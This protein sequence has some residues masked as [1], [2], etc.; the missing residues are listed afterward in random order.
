MLGEFVLPSGGSAWTQ[1][2][3]QLL[4]ELE[5]KEKAG[6][7]AI[8]RMHE[9]GWLDR[10]R[11]GRQTRWSL[12]PESRRV[13]EEGAARIYG[14]GTAAPAWDGS[15]AVVIASVPEADR[16]LRYRMGVGLRWV[17]FGSLGQGVWVCP[18]A[19]RD[20]EAAALLGSLGVEAMSFR[21]PLGE[22]G[23]GTDVAQQAWDL[24]ELR[25]AYDAFLPVDG[26][27]PE[28][29]EGVRAA[30]RLTRLVH[31][32]RR[33]PGID[34]ELPDALLPVD[35]PGRAA[36]E[37]FAAERR[38]LLDPALRWWQVVESGAGPTKESNG[39]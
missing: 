38:R 12:T 24:D 31:R 22:L 32:W 37:R 28:A 39:R 16:H 36:A 33:F 29:A 19:E 6:R 30:A 17:G 2:L 25:A 5:V 1:N 35:W 11:V 27:A 34:P 21:G 10:E 8:A 18:W 9:G 15:W 4:D 3:L 13:L 26:D 20:A 23:T 7:Q 14:F